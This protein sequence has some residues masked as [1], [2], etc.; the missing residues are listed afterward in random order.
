ISVEDGREFQFI[1]DLFSDFRNKI[2]YF[3]ESISYLGPMRPEPK[4]VFAIDTAERLRWEKR[5]ELGDF[6]RFLSKAKADKEDFDKVDWWLKEKLKFGNKF[7]RESSEL[8][9]AIIAKVAVEQSEDGPV[10]NLREVGYGTSQV[11]PILVL[12]VFAKKRGGTFVIIEQPELHLHPRA[13]AD[14]ADL[15]IDA[16]YDIKVE[17]DEK[18][19][20]ENDQ[21]R[22][23]R[24]RE[25]HDIRFLLE[26]HSEHLLLRFRRR[27][28]ET[29]AGKHEHPVEPNLA[30][31]SGDLA[32]Y[33][34]GR[35]DTKSFVEEIVLGEFG[36]FMNI[37]L[38]FEDFFSDDSAETS[39]M[40]RARLDAGLNWKG[41]KNDFGN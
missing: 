38:G 16:I 15:F 1:I 11:L 27:L 4:R 28:A 20:D 8:E 41:K 35:P 30:V 10:I 31:K 14:L 34:V 39:L 23:K 32:I 21:P 2:K 33:F 12:G 40:V 9:Q 13:Q 5:G 25:K 3:L 7:N 18:N 36:E 22:I 17:I 6:L 19:K 24:Y 37:P 29:S 26:T